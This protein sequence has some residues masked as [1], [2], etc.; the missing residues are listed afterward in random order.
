MFVLSAMKM[1]TNI[2]AP[3][4][5]YINRML[6]T[7]GDSVDADDLLATIGEKQAA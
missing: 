4:A 6:V 1:E 5:G 2:P 7:T 3:A